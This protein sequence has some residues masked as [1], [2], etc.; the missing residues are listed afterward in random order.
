MQDNARAHFGDNIFYGDMYLVQSDTSSQQTAAYP[1]FP[2]APRLFFA[3]SEE[4]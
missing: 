4:K 2:V 3:D 1:D